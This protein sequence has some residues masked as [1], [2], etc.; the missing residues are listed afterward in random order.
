MNERYLRIALWLSL[1]TIGYNFL[2]GIISVF[3]G[4]SDE[5]L[6]LFGFGIDS[7]VEVIS[8]AGIFHMI[9][10]IYQHGVEKQSHF[11]KT[12][13]KITAFSFFLLGIVLIVVS[14]Y[15]LYIGSIPENTFWGIIISLISLL[16][17]GFLIFYKIKVGKKLN[18]DAII[19]DA[20]CTLTC[21]YLSIILLVSSGLFYFLKIS[22]ADSIGAIGLALFSLK[23]GK[24]ALEKSKAKSCTHC[25]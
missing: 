17:M 2:E 16:A 12:A 5:T 13:L 1:I 14:L 18:S 8:G 19:A 4:F 9:M 11:E 3:L 21:M 15:K 10:R 24:E 7:F 25:V 20:K 6:A 23:E 22:W